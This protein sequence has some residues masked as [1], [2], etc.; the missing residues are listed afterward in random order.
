MKKSIFTLMLVA[1]ATGVMAQ[2][3]THSVGATVGTLYGVSYKGFIISDNLALEVD[4]GVNLMST[5]VS[6]TMTYLGTKTTTSGTWN[7]CYTFEVNPNILYQAGIANW[8]FGGLAWYAGGGVSIGFIDDIKYSGNPS[9]KWGVNATGGVELKL[10][11]VPLAISFDFRPGYG[12]YTDSADDG[13]GNKISIASSFFDWKLAAG[14][15][16]TF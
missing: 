15:R 14:V 11:S 8:D 3:Y 2:G 16:Y 13:G 7:G 9:F 4:L 10:S 12:M 5:P 6:S 1:L